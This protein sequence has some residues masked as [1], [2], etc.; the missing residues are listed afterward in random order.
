MTTDTLKK[1]TDEYLE[2]LEKS[3]SKFKSKMKA[4][5]SNGQTAVSLSPDSVEEW[6]LNRIVVF[7]SIQILLCT[8]VMTF[9]LH[10]L[11][12]IITIITVGHQVA[13]T[14]QVANSLWVRSAQVL[15]HLLRVKLSSN[16][17]NK[18]LLEWKHR[19]V[20]IRTNLCLNLGRTLTCLGKDLLRVAA[21]INSRHILDRAAA[22][23]TLKSLRTKIELNIDKFFNKNLQFTVARQC[24]DRLKA[25]NREQVQVNLQQV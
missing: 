15:L 21:V 7:S 22:V 11:S 6:N 17:N 25:Q 18:R 12:T 20:A 8:L 3:P 10:R 1:L 9:Q 19:V 14:M 5:T 13:L 24:H 4:I 2:I 23:T 16:S